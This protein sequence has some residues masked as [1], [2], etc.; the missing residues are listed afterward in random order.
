MVNG[1]VTVAFAKN[2]VML[3]EW[4]TLQASTGRA[5]TVRN[6]IAH[7]SLTIETLKSGTN[8]HSL[9]PQMLH[10]S[11]YSEALRKPQKHFLTTKRLAQSSE[12]F[13]RVR[14]ELNAF[15]DRAAK[16]LTPLK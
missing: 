10:L 9:G 13:F 6:K 11:A 14:D 12:T 4:G 8:R 3:T 2:D 5:G 7:G 1:A 15:C 16:L